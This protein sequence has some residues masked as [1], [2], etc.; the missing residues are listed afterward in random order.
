MYVCVC[1]CVRACTLSLWNL[2][3][4]VYIQHISIRTSH[5]ANAQ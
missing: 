4:I 1:V 2:V 3:W 5:M